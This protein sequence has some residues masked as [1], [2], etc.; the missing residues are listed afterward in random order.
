MMARKLTVES[1]TRAPGFLI[2]RLLGWGAAIVMAPF[3]SGVSLLGIGFT[4][5]VVMGGKKTIKRETNARMK[6]RV[7]DMG[8]EF[9]NQ[10][11]KGRTCGSKS[12]E[13][14]LGDLGLGKVYREYKYKIE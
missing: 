10:V 8:A 14:D 12:F 6:D 1:Q 2:T 13:V 5:L 4:E 3:T 7:F 11:L 9:K